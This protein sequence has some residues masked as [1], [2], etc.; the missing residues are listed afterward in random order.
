[1]ATARAVRDAYDTR[2]A[3]LDLN[4]TQASILAYVQQFGPVTQT[5]IADH[6]LLGRAVIGATIDRLQQRGLLERLA[7]VDDRRVWR[8]TLSA[9]GAS[10]AAQVTAVDEV[11]RGEMRTGISRSERQ[12]LASVLTRLQEN[13]LRVARPPTH[14]T[15]TTSE[16]P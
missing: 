4:L 7:D 12:A 1:M 6:L 13:L 8:V 16:T 11:L 5:K 14:P 2:L 15:T 9:N 3:P 10:V